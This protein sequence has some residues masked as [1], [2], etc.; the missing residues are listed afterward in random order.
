[1]W[2]HVVCSRRNTLTIRA[3]QGQR[4]T[5]AKRRA[6][7][8]KA[9]KKGSSLDR[10]GTKS[11]S[12]CSQW[13]LNWCV[14]SQTIIFT[15]V[16]NTSTAIKTSIPW[17]FFQESQ[18]KNVGDVGDVG[19]VGVEGSSFTV[20]L[21]LLKGNPRITAK[22]LATQLH[23]ATRTAERILRQLKQCERIRRS[24]NTRTGYWI[25]EEI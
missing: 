14:D 22:E 3:P 19:D 6:A 16:A 21:Q 5:A 13:R 18:V 15:S 10:G 25:V 17:V 20:V 1:M 11:G 7:V 4:N 2:T 24:G 8:G 9:I 12:L 23:T